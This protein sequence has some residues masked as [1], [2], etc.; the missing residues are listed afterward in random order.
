MLAEGTY[1]V[2]GKLLALVYI[3]ANLADVALFALALG[4]GLD[5]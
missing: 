1:K 3:S 2:F 5:V 4:F